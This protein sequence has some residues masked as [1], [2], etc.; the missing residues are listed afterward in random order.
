VVNVWMALSDVT[1]E[2]GPMELLAGSHLGGL[3]ET[4]DHYVANNMLTRGQIIP[5]LQFP[6]GPDPDRLTP[7]LLRPGEYSVHHLQTAHG[8]GPNRGGGRRIGFNVTYAA[9]HVTNTDG[10]GL[11]IRGAGAGSHGGGAGAEAEAGAE[12]TIEPGLPGL[13]ERA[14][15]QGARGKPTAAAAAA[16]SRRND[17]MSRAIMDGADMQAFA[18]VSEERRGVNLPPHVSGKSAAA[19]SLAANLLQK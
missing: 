7:A 12:P 10:G 3:L 8:G 9:A 14:P 15:Q 13:V 6:P 2:S 16:H 19:T 1:E 11:L 17:A 18:R 4:G 5:S